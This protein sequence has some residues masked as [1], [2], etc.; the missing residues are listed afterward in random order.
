M[1]ERWGTHGGATGARHEPRGTAYVVDDERRTMETEGPR[2]HGVSYPAWFAFT[3]SDSVWSEDGHGR[4]R[5]MGWK[6]L[7]RGP[8]GSAVGNMRLVVH[9]RSTGRVFREGIAIDPVAS[10]F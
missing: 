3:T 6:I 7:S 8:C 1:G 2:G 10:R 9:R 5:V 4:I